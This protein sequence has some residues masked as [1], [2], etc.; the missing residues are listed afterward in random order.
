MNNLEKIDKIKALVSSEPSGWKARAQFRQDNHKWLERSSKIALLILRQLKSKGISQ[1]Q[2]AKMLN[3]S[4]Q[5]VSKFVKGQENL[6]LETISKIEEALNI[7]ILIID[8]MDIS[9]VREPSIR[10]DID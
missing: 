9:E 10:H 4:P 7:D 1:T 2:F 3:V 5:Q 8:H 6:T